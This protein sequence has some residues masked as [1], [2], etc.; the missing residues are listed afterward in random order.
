MV[1]NENTLL[2]LGDLS[3]K[4]NVEVI[5]GLNGD[6]YLLKGNHEFKRIDYLNNGLKV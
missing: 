5:K 2:H 6:K 1:K 3:F 4:G